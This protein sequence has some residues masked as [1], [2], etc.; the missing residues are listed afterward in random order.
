MHVQ[1]DS[2]EQ[3]MHRLTARSACTC[4]LD[5]YTQ[6]LSRQHA[7]GLLAWQSRKPRT[8]QPAAR[9]TEAWLTSAIDQR[10]LH[11]DLLASGTC[12]R[13]QIA[14]CMQQTRS[15]V[16]LQLLSGQAQLTIIIMTMTHVKSCALR[17]FGCQT[18]F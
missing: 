15:S 14:I 5:N 6:L 8:V 12:S 2:V 9:L 10:T 4:W 11:P 7:C 16:V 1:I 3:L 17:E 13:T 18:V